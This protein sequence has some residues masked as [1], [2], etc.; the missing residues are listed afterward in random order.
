MRHLAV[1]SASA[2][3]FALTLAARGGEQDITKIPWPKVVAEFPQESPATFTVGRYQISFREPN[4]P[5]IQS[6]GGSGGPMVEY[7]LRDKKTGWKATLLEQSTGQ[8][9]LEDY[10]G[11][12]QLEIWGRGGGGSW[13]RE[14]YRYIDGEYRSVRLDEFEETPHHHNEGALRAEMPSSRQGRGDDQEEHL[15]FVETRLP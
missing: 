15:Y 3:V 7:V 1:L 13:S 4:D 12:P 14:L 5:Q 6:L 9:V 10:R 11:R 2:A 8:R